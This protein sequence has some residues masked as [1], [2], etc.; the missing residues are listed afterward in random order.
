LILFAYE[1]RRKINDRFFKKAAKY[2]SWDTISA[3]DIIPNS[4]DKVT[5]YR[6]KKKS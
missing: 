4:Q 2:F 1:R 6:M 5:L 3:S